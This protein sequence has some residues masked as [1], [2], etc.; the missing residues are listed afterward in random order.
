MPPNSTRLQP[1]RGAFF[2]AS[3]GSTKNS[4][5]KTFW[6]AFIVPRFSFA[7][8]TKSQLKFLIMNPVALVTQRLLTEIRAI[9]SLSGSN[10]TMSYPGIFVYALYPGMPRI[11]NS[12][13]T[14]NSAPLDSSRVSRRGNAVSL[15]NANLVYW[16]CLSRNLRLS[17]FD[18]ICEKARVI[19]MTPRCLQ[20]RKLG[21]RC[22]YGDGSKH[23]GSD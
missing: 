5:D 10:A 8:T 18:S 13:S 16:I 11:N 7:T 3:T 1:L 19:I 20:Q 4:G 12:P 17:G 22:V 9:L 14:R 15:F 23:H 6:G 21:F 2:T